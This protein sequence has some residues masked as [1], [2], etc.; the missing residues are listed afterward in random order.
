M[1]AVIQPLVATPR[2][3][4]FE[5]LKGYILRVSEANGYHTPL[6]MLSSTGMTHGEMISIIPPLEKLAPLFDCSITEMSK[7]G[8]HK[9]LGSSSAKRMWLHNHQLPTS[10]LN[11]KSPKICIDCILQSGFTDSF[12]DLKYA[13]ACPKH[14]KYLLKIC[15]E[16]K[17][18][19]SWFRPGLL[20]C[21]CGCDLSH[22]SGESLNNQTVLGMLAFMRNQLRRDPLDHNFYSQSLGFPIEHLTTL[23]LS[24][25]LS[26][27]VRFENKGGYSMRAS[28]GQ[29]IYQEEVTLAKV[30]KALENWPEG[31]Y[32][33]LDS[34]N[35][36]RVSTKGFGL[37]KQF[38]SFYGSLFKSDIPKEKIAFIKEAFIEYGNHH[39]KQGY[40]FNNEENTKKVVGIY[41]LAEVLGVMPSTAKNLVKKG[42]ITGKASNLNG[43][44]RQFFDVNN[45]LPIKSGIGKTLALRKA[46]AWLGLP[47]S[48]LKV[49]RDQQDFLVKHIAKPFS[50]YH[51]NDL[52]VFRDQL[53]NLCPSI[54]SI[55]I[56]E[57]FTL[58]QV[59]QMKVGS[60]QIK[61]NFV[62]AILDAEITPLGNVDG[63]IQGMFFS[64][65]Q[66][67]EFIATQKAALFGHITVVS[68][69]KELHCDPLVVKSLAEEK[70]LMAVKKTNGLFIQ[71]AS[72]KE[73]GSRYLSC[74]YLARGQNTSTSKILEQCIK[75]NICVRWF[76]RFGK[77][78]PQPFMEKPLAKL[79]WALK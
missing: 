51:M 35:H 68:A 15:P 70:L 78:K 53:L 45:E 47:T 7:L 29:N 31:L 14:N 16:C 63:A 23:T 50:A 38:E 33:Y 57:H 42:L 24:E 48:I 66:V 54:K 52:I 19:L 11:I 59:M 27:I 61:A 21:T 69:A 26:I 55:L 44:T 67:D 39:W 17:K 20:K 32:Q 72:I 64:K 34:F 76:P 30:S 36:S 3:Y 41:G 77:D 12:W 2:H 74:A 6:M 40:V 79:K 46:A 18:H 10:Y 25:L 9:P 49:L 71:N 60:T 22:L 8:Y 37:R 43:R 56:D 73:F 1:T 13:I 58:K 65:L 4:K 28:E 5:S 75:Q 62:K